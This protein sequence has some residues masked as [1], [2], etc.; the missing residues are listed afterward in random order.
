MVNK[1]DQVTERVK[2]G[3]ESV[4]RELWERLN[5]SPNGDL[6]DRDY[7]ARYENE[8]GE[9]DPDEVG[10]HGVNRLFFALD[11]LGGE[12]EKPVYVHLLISVVEIYLAEAGD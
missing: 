4:S 6:T 9:I 1:S 5:Q 12:G 10:L 7:L 8:D 11:G 2:S 3:T